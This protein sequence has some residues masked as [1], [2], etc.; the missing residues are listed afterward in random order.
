[1]SAVHVFVLKH[2]TAACVAQYK[3]QSMPAGTVQLNAR[4]VV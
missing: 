2:S 4:Q 1:M 3:L